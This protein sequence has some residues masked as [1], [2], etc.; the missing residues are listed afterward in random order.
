MVDQAGRDLS[1]HQRR[2]LIA[3][4]VFRSKIAELGGQVIEIEWL[5]SKVPHRCICPKGPDSFRRP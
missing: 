1:F 2:S 5:G 4:D 3:W